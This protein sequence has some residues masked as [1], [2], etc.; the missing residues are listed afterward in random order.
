M[1]NSTDLT[2]PFLEFANLACLPG[3]RWATRSDYNAC[4]PLQL[5][6]EGEQVADQEDK[7][8]HHHHHHNHHRH[9]HHPQENNTIIMVD[10][11]RCGRCPTPPPSPTSTS[12]ATPSA[13][14]LSQL[15]FSSSH[16]SSWSSLIISIC[17]ITQLP[18]INMLANSK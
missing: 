13:W 2:T 7:H 11:R 4:V 14:P 8:H 12:P 9:H 3:P 15:P 18:F 17:Y 1:N 6:E 10:T 5:S 16:T